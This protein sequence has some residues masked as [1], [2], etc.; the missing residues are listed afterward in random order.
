MGGGG[1]GGN[2]EAKASIPQWAE[3]A[4]KK[5]IG[6]ANDLASVGYMPWMGPDVAALNPMQ[7]QA[8]QGTASSASAF[9]LAP[10]GFDAMAGMPEAQDFGGGMMGYSSFPMYE[11]AKNE[12]ERYAPNQAGAYND[13]FTDPGTPEGYQFDPSGMGTQMGQAMG[14]QL[15]QPAQDESMFPGID[16]GKDKADSL[17][18][19]ISRMRGGMM[20]GMF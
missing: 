1:K 10:D 9:G 14:P 6:L 17:M 13:I 8:M 16:R 18:S 15:A 20:G 4:S 2:T 7:Q 11:Q 19:L 12:F 5:N 3:D